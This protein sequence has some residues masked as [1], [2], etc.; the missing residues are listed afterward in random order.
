[1]GPPILHGIFP[2][3]GHGSNSHWRNPDLTAFW[4]SFAWISSC[5]CWISPSLD[6]GTIEC[7]KLGKTA[8]SWSILMLPSFQFCCLIAPHVTQ[9]FYVFAVVAVFVGLLL[10]MMMMMR[11]MMM[12]LSQATGAT[13]ATF[14]GADDSLAASGRSGVATGG[15]CL[16]QQMLDGYPRHPQTLSSLQLPAVPVILRNSNHFWSRRKLLSENLKPE[17]SDPKVPQT[18]IR[19]S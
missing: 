15:R 17:L 12:M 3:Y 4:L 5:F 18:P 2:L 6:L 10:L 13:E 9:H 19:K 1:M 11:M 7:F 14:P 8:L 16:E